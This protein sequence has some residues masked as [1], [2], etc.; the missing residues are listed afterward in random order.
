[1]GWTTAFQSPSQTPTR[2]PEYAIPE[3]EAT[4]S[5]PISL[6][7]R[8]MVWG[9]LGHAANSPYFLNSMWLRFWTYRQFK[10]RRWMLVFQTPRRFRILRPKYLDPE[11]EATCSK[12]ISL[13]KRAMVWWTEGHAAN[14]PYF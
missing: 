14:S 4:C 2:C 5:K 10:A 8:A 1:M 12:P 6:S 7:I 9:S 11:M 3:T 13:S